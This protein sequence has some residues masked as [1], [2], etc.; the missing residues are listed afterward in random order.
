MI[1]KSISLE[2]QQI[3]SSFNVSK[4]Y[5]L[6]LLIVV[7]SPRPSSSS[8]SFDCVTSLFSCELTR[9]SL[10]I[11]CPCH[12]IGL[13][14][15]CNVSSISCCSRLSSPSRSRSF[16]IM[17]PSC[18]SVVSCCFLYLLSLC[19]R[20]LDSLFV[21]IFSAFSSILTLRSS[22]SRRLVLAL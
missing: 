6:T 13:S 12:E 17:A 2:N 22:V 9:S 7:S 4:E 5:A 21:L 8:S 18:A 14:F 16:E 15:T 20:A 1:R 19:F 11:L 3:I 10:E